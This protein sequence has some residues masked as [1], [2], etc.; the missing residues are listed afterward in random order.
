MYTIINWINIHNHFSMIDKEIFN[1]KG[2]HLMHLNIRSLFCKNKFNMFQQQMSKSNIDIICL[3]ETWLKN[4]IHSN[5]VNIPSYNL[6]RLDRNWSDNGS[7]KKGG[8]VGMYIKNDIQFSDNELKHL[9][10][11]SIDIEVQWVSIKKQNN[12]K[13]YV[14]NV[15]RPP[16]GNIKNFLQNIQ[17]CLDSFDERSKK[18]IFIVGDFNIDIKKKSESNSKNLIQT[19]NTFGLKQYIN[20][21]TR[22][23]KSNS[24]IDLIFTNSEYICNSGILDLNFSDHQAVFITKKKFKIKN[25]KIEFKGRSYK[26]DI[27]DDFQDSLKLMDWEEFF[28][29]EDPNESWDLLYNRINSTLEKMCPEKKIK[30][31]EYREDWMNKDLMERI[32]DKDKALKKAKK[33][34]NLIDWTNAKKL[35][36]E[37]GKLVETA[38]KQHFQEEYE[39]S[40]DDPKRFWRNI[41]D[42]IPN[43]K[44]N[45]TVIHL[46]S[47]EGDEVKLDKTAKYINDYFTNIG[48]KLASKFNERWKYFGNETENDIDEINVIEGYVYDFVKEIDIC[49]S[50]GFSEISSMCLRD[51]L[52]VL[53]PQLLYIF[54]QSV[55][56][57]KFPEKWKIATIVPIFK[58]GNK[59]EVSNYRPVSL[60]PVTGKIFEKIL[61]YQIVNFLDD[62]KFLSD[63]QN[64]FRKEKSTLGSIVSFTSDIFETI[65]DRKFTLATFIDLKKAF[66]TVNHKILLE[67]LYY[68]AGIKGKTLNLLENY[69]TNRFQ[70]TFSNG[71]TSSL[72]KITCGVPQGSILGPL[73]F[74]IYI[75]DLEGVLGN[76]HFHLYADDTVIYCYN[77]NIAMA[78]KEMQKILNKFSKWCSINALTINTNKTKTM[79]FGSR[80]KIKNSY[81]PELYINNEMLQI[82]P[83]YKYLGVNLDQTLSF[84]YHLENLINNISFKLYMFSKVRRFINEKCAITVYKSMLMPFFDYCDIIYMYS[85]Q[86]ELNKLNR[87]H[88]RGMKICVGGGYRLDENELHI[89]CNLAELAIRRQVHL[90]NFMFKIK[91][92][93]NN[94]NSNDNVH[95]KTRLH[96]GP[97]FNVTH[98]NSEPIKRSVMYAGALDW[99]N[100]ESDIRNIKDFSSFKRQQKAW[101]LN[102]ILD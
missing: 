24:C 60:L 10:S 63:K 37:V 55:N 32:I 40:K 76:N 28:D 43:N 59:E 26:N 94:L 29:I 41:Y 25:S 99:N 11:S 7:L 89:K 100:L 23:G 6:S 77:E 44:N 73:F 18:D 81:K 98:P 78:E 61:H 90:R 69:L 2:F 51:A 86:K 57:G 71:K 72:N 88:I 13:M 9:N 3:S 102:S 31:N 22:Y 15:Y 62:N 33:T 54:K 1:K 14:A 42:I 80:N 85:G 19:M 75:N 82:V 68:L 58:G 12:R 101:M 27:I 83:T 93:E 95:V 70:K 5:Y 50:S 38:R 91:R 65:N 92:N 20:G 4:G 21:I 64:G 8:G 48:P 74:L 30:I 97:V 66:D 36:N 35:R 17:N 46:K 96:D 87:H 16:Q 53:I 79:V 47:Q 56:T 45:K 34:N 49:K 39:H 52:I 84:K 67:K